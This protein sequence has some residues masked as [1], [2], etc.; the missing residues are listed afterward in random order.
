MSMS[1]NQDARFWNNFLIVALLVHGVLLG[2]FILARAVGAATQVKHVRAEP[3]HVNAVN[4][5]T[6][7]FAK[8]AV[9]GADNSALAVVE[10]ASGAP[11]AAVPKTGEE[12]YNA[13]CTACHG[14]GIGGAPKFGDKVAWA[15]H[16]A[17]GI[18]ILNQ[19]A[20]E[21]FQGPNGLMP[22]KGGRVDLSD[23]VIRAGVDYMVE[24]SR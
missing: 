18:E 8:I 14:Q 1:A 17:K 6:R 19:H 5:R 3:A 20:I 9:A 2:F 12:V 7:P 24:H 21:G 22:P 10:E 23:D 13:A 16:I 15:P 4:A 11:V